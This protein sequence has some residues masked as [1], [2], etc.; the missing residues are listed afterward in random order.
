M[1]MITRWCLSLEHAGHLSHTTKEWITESQEPNSLLSLAKATRDTNAS[2]PRDK[3]YSLLG[4]LEEAGPVDIIPDYSFPV[5]E[6]YAKATITCINRHSLGHL[7]MCPSRGTTELLPSWAI[8]FSCLPDH[9]FYWMDILSDDHTDIWKQA[10]DRPV[11]SADARCLHIT[12]VVS[13]RLHAICIIEYPPEVWHNTTNVHNYL[14]SMW[15]QFIS[16]P[17]DDFR[18]SNSIPIREFN[19]SRGDLYINRA[20]EHCAREWRQA[21]WPQDA[22]SSAPEEYPNNNNRKMSFLSIMINRTMQRVR[23]HDDGLALAVTD[24]G[25]FGVTSSR[26]EVGDAVVY[27]SGSQDPLILRRRGQEWSLRGLASIDTPF[28]SNGVA[29]WKIDDWATSQQIERLSII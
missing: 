10:R 5:W 22:I 11:L 9:S 27:A 3:V 4:L 14:Q 6:V 26:C 21:C 13:A 7:G 23:H 24:N 15:A 20:F 12:G 18:R 2:D 8:D 28:I 17:F 29:E 1:R 25:Y 16:L 19:Y